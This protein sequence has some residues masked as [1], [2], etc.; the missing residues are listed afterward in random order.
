MLCVFTVALGSCKKNEVREGKGLTNKH[1]EL[2]GR[3]R[4]GINDVLGYSY[5][6]LGEFG[7][8]S[9]V[10]LPVI[11]VDK[12]Y[13]EQPTKIIWDLSTGTR[14]ILD[15]GSDA[16]SYLKKLTTRLSTTF[17][18][19]FLGFSLFKATVT[20]NYNNTDNF[21]AK[22]IYSSYDLKVQQKR[23]KFNALN[24][25]LQSYLDPDFLS[26]VQT[27][28]PEAI[29]NRYGTHVL[30]DII[31]GGKLN[32]IYKSETSK[33]DKTV[34]S[35]AGID[36]NVKKI[37][38][39]NTGYTYDANDVRENSSQQLHYQT[40]GGDPTKSLLGDI[41]IG[42]ASNPNPTPNVN[43]SGWQSSCTLENSVLID[44][45]KDGLL[46]IYDLIP[47]QSKANAV[48]NYIIQY[49]NDNQAQLVNGYLN[50]SPVGVYYSQGLNV[51]RYEFN[52]DNIPY[53]RDGS[54]QY[55]QV[56]F[57]AFKEQA[58]GTIPIYEYWAPTTNDCVWD[59]SGNISSDPY[60]HFGGI[61]FY[62]YST[63]QPGTIPIYRYYHHRS[64]RSHF[65]GT[66][67][68]LPYPQ[69]E[70]TNEG[71]VFYAFPAR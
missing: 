16:T 61:K 26:Y 17:G 14:G 19:E 57:S 40:I 54:W 34:A 21:S 33:S 51:W 2:A 35:S 43:I 44:I 8:S 63:Q 48:K 65:L 31:L 15:A 28:T 38:N 25:V 23:I 64:R 55:K 9:A 45:A 68:G 66:D 58:P 70:W 50:P 47:D 3:G 52:I 56:Y 60:W 46:P 7:N 18:Y 20:A 59:K 13:Q 4:D 62:A 12:L 30:S 71:I 1:N 10:K 42:N 22:Y 32:I 5:D 53:L 36:L 49:L 29:V 37:F 11:N 24:D 6:V 41:A 39:L 67:P 69:N 27:Q